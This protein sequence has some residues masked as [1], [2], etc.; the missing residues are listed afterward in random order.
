MNI[1]EFVHESVTALNSTMIDDVKEL[2]PEQLAWQP[3]PNANPIG[4]I[5]WHFMRV[6]DG[7][8]HGFQGRPQLWESE[9]WYEKMGM[10]VKVSGGGFQEPEVQKVAA[11]PLADLLAYAERV[12][13][14][15]SDYF[16]SLTDADFDRAPNPDRP[17]RTIAVTVR[18]FLIGHGWWHAGE[19]KY[20]RGMQGMPFPM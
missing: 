9:K 20:L 6:Q 11:L 1:T 19:I 17:R 12:S 4:F 7:M 3:A 10:D 2:T 13:E 15:S 16:K 5:F 8:I 18:A 14:V